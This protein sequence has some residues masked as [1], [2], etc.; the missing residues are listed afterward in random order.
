MKISACRTRSFASFG[1]ILSFI[2][3]GFAG[4]YLRSSSAAAVARSMVVPVPTPRKKV[5]RTRPSRYSDFPHSVKAHQLECSSCHKFPSDNWNK[6]RTGSDAF[7]DITDYP[8]HESCVGCHKQQFFKG[9]PP[10]VC[11]IC[12]TNPGPRDSSRHPYENPREIFDQSPKGKKAPESD[13]AI[14]FPHDKHIDIVSLNVS[15]SGSIV[16]ASYRKPMA[17]ESCNVC[18]KTYQPQGEGKDEFVTPPPANIGEAFWLKKGT[19]KTT[20]IGHTTCFTC[21]SQDSG[22]EPTPQKCATCHKLRPPSGPTDF[23]PKVAAK[24][25]IADKIM[26]TQWRHRDSSATFRHE[27]DVHSSLECATCHAA[28]KMNT[29]DVSTK[30]VPISA[31]AMCH[32]TPTTADGGALNVEVDK[33]KASAT[34]QCVKCHIAF[35]RMAI[36]ESHTQ[37][38]TA[39]K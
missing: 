11:S 25:N 33:R 26:L 36:P 9:R 28:A 20:P 8:K 24:M 32:A 30:K 17:E 19:F 34:F 2:G 27:F 5:A 10:V 31:C 13:F 4:F 39:S 18:H 29:L 12:H 3:L 23:D 21:H 6:V 14:S 22:I 1:V 16:D 7:P 35:G 15:Q 37:A 38:L